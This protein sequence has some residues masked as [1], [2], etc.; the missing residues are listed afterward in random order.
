MPLLDDQAVIARRGERVG[1][2]L[3]NRLPVVMD[4]VGLAVH[5]P[6]RPATTSAAADKADALVPEANAQQ[7]ELRPEMADDVV[8][9]P[10][11]AGRAGAGLITMCVGLNC[12]TS[13][14]V[15]LSLRNTRIVQTAVEPPPTSAP[16][17]R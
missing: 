10:A 9:D 16:G 4:L 5:Q 14:T 2:A 17:C 13:S 11:F 3:V 7:R 12:S 8:G 6:R 15:T 1:H